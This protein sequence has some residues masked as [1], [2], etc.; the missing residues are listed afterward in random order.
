MKI[1]IFVVQLR[2]L[3]TLKILEFNQYLKSDKVLFFT[4]AGPQCLIEDIDVC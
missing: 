3:K 1:K 4:Y 2:L